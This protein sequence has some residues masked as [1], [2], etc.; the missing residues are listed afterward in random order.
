MACAMSERKISCVEVPSRK[1]APGGSKIW[2]TPTKETENGS[3]KRLYVR[4]ARRR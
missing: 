4:L 1:N 3:E 2:T